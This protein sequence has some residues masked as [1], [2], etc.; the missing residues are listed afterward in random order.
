M[1][2]G[3]E[4]AQRAAGVVA[5]QRHAVELQRVQQV[6]DQPRDAGR[7]E[8][9]VAAHRRRVRAERQIGHD[10]AVVGGEPLDD[11]LP[12]PPVDQQAVHEHQR[13]PAAL[14]AIADRALRHRNLWHGRRSSASRGA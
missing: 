8:V 12:Q 13:R 14:I 11:R 7:R 6:G 10:A 5:D 1:P 4:L 3:D 9:G 2:H